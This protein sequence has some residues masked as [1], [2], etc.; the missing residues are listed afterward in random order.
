[1]TIAGD[2]ALHLARRFGKTAAADALVGRGASTGLQ[3]KVGQT[4]LEVEKAAI[5]NESYE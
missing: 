5:T 2:T 1:M 4:P 3:N